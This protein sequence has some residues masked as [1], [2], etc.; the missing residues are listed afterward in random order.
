MERY[1]HRIITALD[2]IPKFKEFL[3]RHVIGDPVLPTARDLVA[4]ITHVANANQR[5]EWD[6]KAKVAS[7][8][9]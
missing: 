1:K 6:L 8:D 7:S 3:T 4:A 5:P 9:R 2:G